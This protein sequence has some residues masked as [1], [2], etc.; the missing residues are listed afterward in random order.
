MATPGMRLAR[1]LNVKVQYE[2]SVRKIPATDVKQENGRIQAFD[3]DKKVAEFPE[4]RIEYWS[5]ETE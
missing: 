5:F 2:N 3:G 4:D 1:V